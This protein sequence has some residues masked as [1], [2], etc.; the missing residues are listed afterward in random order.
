MIL[1]DKIPRPFLAA[2]RAENHSGRMIR[3]QMGS[4]IGKKMVTVAWDALYDTTPQ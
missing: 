4:T 2:T 1:I 3:N